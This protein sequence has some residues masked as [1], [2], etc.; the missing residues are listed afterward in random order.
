MPRY[1]LT[2]IPRDGKLLCADKTFDGYFVDLYATLQEKKG[3]AQAL[4]LQHFDPT[5]P[6]KILVPE[7]DA[8]VSR[9][10][11]PIPTARGFGKI[12]L[13]F[14]QMKNSIRKHSRQAFKARSTIKI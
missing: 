1:Q 13:F 10:I 11:I 14:E 7:A 3:L 12:R 6:K 8:L 5:K 4:V 9:T 2:F